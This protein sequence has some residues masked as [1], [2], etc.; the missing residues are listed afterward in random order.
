MRN[1]DI[2][3][4]RMRYFTFVSLL[5]IFSGPHIYAWTTWPKTLWPRGIMRP[6]CTWTS[7]KLQYKKRRNCGGVSINKELPSKHHL[8][9]FKATELV[10]T[11]WYS[12]DCRFLYVMFSCCLRVFLYGVS[13]AGLVHVYMRRRVGPLSDTQVAR[14][15]ISAT[16]ASP[17][18][19]INTRTI[20]IGNKAWAEPAR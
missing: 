17:P 14:A 9:N 16:R 4:H 13:R 3:N 12:C 18:S 7:A 5:S 15:E 6:L 19:H 1:A 8:S 20:L 11:N 10:E 2:V